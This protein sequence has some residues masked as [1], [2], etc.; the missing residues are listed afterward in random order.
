MGRPIWPDLRCTPYGL[1]EMT[2]GNT[3]K[4]NCELNYYG[5][6]A[7]Y[8]Y[9]TLCQDHMNRCWWYLSPPLCEWSLQRDWW[10]MCDWLLLYSFCV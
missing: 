4:A 3:S 9:T 6:C 1:N 10:A 8:G 2:Y 7:V 5:A